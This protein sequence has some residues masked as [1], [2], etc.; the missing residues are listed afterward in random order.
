MASKQLFFQK[1]T[2]VAQRLRV[3]SPHLHSLQLLRPQ[4]SAC[5]TLESHKFAHQASPFR[6]FFE[7]IFRLL[8]EVPHLAQS[9]L[10]AYP[11]PNFNHS[12]CSIFFPI[13]ISSFRKF[14]MTSLHVTCGLGPPIKNLGYAYD[15]TDVAKQIKL[16]C[17]F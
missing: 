16:F 2:K 10:R 14:L 12:L 5:G 4:T 7:K 6:R 8:V 17:L 11:G 13:E 1:I 9:W 15:K 3:L